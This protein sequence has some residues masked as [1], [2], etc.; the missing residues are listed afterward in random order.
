MA[1]TRKQAIKMMKEEKALKKE[2]HS[3]I[4]TFLV[5]LTVDTCPSHETALRNIMT[6]GQKGF[7][8]MRGK[9]LIELFQK[10]YEWLYDNNENINF[11]S[12]S[13]DSYKQRKGYWGT[14]CSVSFEDSVELRREYAMMAETLMTKI[15]EQAVLL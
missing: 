9:E 12:T 2:L 13:N 4:V 11:Y 7:A 14:R 5:D 3:E 10:K 15:F 1:M 8:H 6:D